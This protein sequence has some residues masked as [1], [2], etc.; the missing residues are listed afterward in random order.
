[1]RKI[2]QHL[3]SPEEGG[4]TFFSKKIRVAN[5]LSTSNAL[6]SIV[7]NSTMITWS[8]MW[9][10]AS[11]D[12]ADS[13]APVDRVSS[14]SADQASRSLEE[15][16]K[17]ITWKADNSWRGPWGRRSNHKG[18]EREEFFRLSLT[19]EVI[20]NLIETDWVSCLLNSLDPTR[21]DVLEASGEGYWQLPHHEW[22]I[23]K[24][25]IKALDAIF[26][27]GGTTYSECNGTYTPLVWEPGRWWENE[28]KH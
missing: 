23:C 25:S 9:G 3:K 21:Q 19:E 22:L 26:I 6:S 15:N 1:M 4:R 17:K 24:V 14:Q 16:L 10:W 8:N 13:H 5:T 2:S 28:T 12:D 11:W 20:Y 18:R 7:V 27:V